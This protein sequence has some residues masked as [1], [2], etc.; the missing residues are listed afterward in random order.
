MAKIV[1]PRH[2]L[3]LQYP[4]K[5][6]QILHNHHINRIPVDD[7]LLE[8]A[9]VAG[10]AWCCS[11]ECKFRSFNQR[12]V[13]THAIKEIDE[14]FYMLI[15]IFRSHIIFRCNN[16]SLLFFCCIFLRCTVSSVLPAL[17]QD[18]YGKH[19]SHQCREPLT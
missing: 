2:A 17:R 15:I 5:R 11:P 16:R 19:P 4:L 8:I 3:A 12:F 6:R 14:M 1:E 10:K 9:V 18:R 13:F 7:F